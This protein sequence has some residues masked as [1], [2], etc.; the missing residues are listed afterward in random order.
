M[1]APVNRAKGSWRS[2]LRNFFSNSFECILCGVLKSLLLTDWILN[3]FLT[4][5]PPTFTITLSITILYIPL[6]FLER[7]LSIQPLVL[8]LPPWNKL[9]VLMFALFWAWRRRRVECKLWNCSQRCE[10]FFSEPNTEKHSVFPRIQWEG[11][12]ECRAA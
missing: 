12:G 3:G 4:H 7:C 10:I 5:K 1:C 11:C 6:S 8:W 2:T 9:F